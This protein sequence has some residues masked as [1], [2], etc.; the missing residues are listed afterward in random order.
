MSR[1]ERAQLYSLLLDAFISRNDLEQLF[2]FKL[3]RR[4]G[5]IAGDSD[6]HNDLVFKVIQN[7]EQHGWLSEL[8]WAAVD[9]RQ[10]NKRLAQWAGLHVPQPTSG[11]SR[12]PHPA[13]D[14]REIYG[15][16]ERTV[17]PANLTYESVVIHDGAVHLGLHD[18]DTSRHCLVR[19][20]TQVLDTDVSERQFLEEVSLARE[21][22]FHHRVADLLG[23]GLTMDRHPY[24]IQDIGRAGILRP[25]PLGAAQVIDIGAKLADALTVAHN[26][27]AAYGPIGPPHILLTSDGEP[28]LTFPAVPMLSSAQDPPATPEKDV[29][30]FCATL[31]ALLGSGP[32]HQSGD[33]GETQ[34][35]TLAAPLTSETVM[36]A[37]LREI[38]AVATDRKQIA[39]AVRDRLETLKR[40]SAATRR[41]SRVLARVPTSTTGWR[42]DGEV[43]FV[44]GDLFEQDANLVVGF[45][46]TFDTATDGSRVISPSSLQGQLV[47]R[48]YH[49][50]VEALDADLERALATVDAE[51]LETRSAKRYGKLT[52]YPV[53]TV[54]VLERDRRR[55]FAVAFSRMDNTLT[56]RSTAAFLRLSLGN[57]WE[58]V[59]RHEPDRALAMPVLGAGLSRLE[60]E[61]ETLIN[62]TLTSFREHTRRASVCREL[63]IVLHPSDTTGFAL[64]VGQ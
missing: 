4:L 52:R 35:A 34:Q 14:L 30:G 15:I 32:A 9:Q 64:P 56:T 55:V 23:S 54:A 12:L 27:G 24:L 50:D 13:F 25:A 5:S 62:M 39:A 51:S 61:R 22:S 59:R 20:H 16:V 21:A 63:R 38:C 48:I 41:T 33:T 19:L 57:L 2:F 11:I 1:E 17:G 42:D 43:V 46:D 37:R 28:L 49:G 29:S 6:N 3:S 44:Q 45:S 18:E 47:E 58:T 10:Q 53:G 8:V 26:R 36:A 31:L 7:A 60:L 40:E